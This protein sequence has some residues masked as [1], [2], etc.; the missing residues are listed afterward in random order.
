MYLILLLFLALP[1]HAATI[2]EYFIHVQP[3]KFAGLLLRQ[4]T[5]QRASSWTGLGN[6]DVLW[7]DPNK[8]NDPGSTEHMR[9]RDGWLMLDGFDGSSVKCIQAEIE[10]INSG[11]RM[12]LP[13]DNYYAPWLVPRDPWRIRFW[14]AIGDILVYYE[15]AFY[16]GEQATNPCWY[17]GPQTREV[18]RQQ[19]AWYDTRGGWAFGSG[20]A[21]FDAFGKPLRPMVALGRE[22]TIAKGDGVWTIKDAVPLCAYSTWQWQ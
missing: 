4:D 12:S 3:S 13:C 7:R 16:P 5:H 9:L 22:T 2:S 15:A 14:Q 18:I 20:S 6:G 21:P 8:A 11:E 17:E 1:L 10:D 19:E